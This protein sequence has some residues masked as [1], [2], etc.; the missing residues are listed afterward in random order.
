MEM[1]I[2][3]IEDA[4]PNW[5]D[6]KNIQKNTVRC[7]N[8]R[9]FFAATSSNSQIERSAADHAQSPPSMDNQTF[10]N[11]FMEQDTNGVIRTNSISDNQMKLKQLREKL[12]EY[13][14][15]LDQINNEKTYIENM[16]G[17][18]QKQINLVSG[19]QNSTGINKTV[20]TASTRFHD[21]LFAQNG[22]EQPYPLWNRLAPPHPHY[23]TLNLRQRFLQL[24]NDDIIL[25]L[26]FLL[27]LYVAFCIF[28]RVTKK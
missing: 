15:Y 3:A 11:T 12:Q 7:K 21:H 2:C 22:Y 14:L 19:D 25:I 1:N 17:L 16:L 8:D 10:S 9:P 6:H 20:E 5:N 28:N 23:N 13:H 26:G 24:S 18:F 4:F 27:I